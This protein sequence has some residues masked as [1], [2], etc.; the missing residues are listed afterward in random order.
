MFV[1]TIMFNVSKQCFTL[2]SSE[3]ILK[4]G[5]KH[6]FSFEALKVNLMLQF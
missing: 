4:V 3:Y 1:Y 6:Y 2:K 5:D